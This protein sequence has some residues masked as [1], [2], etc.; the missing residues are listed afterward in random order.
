MTGKPVG[1]LLKGHVNTLPIDA[2]LSPEAETRPSVYGM[3][4]NV[5]PC[6][7]LSF[8]TQYI[9]T[10]LFGWTQMVGLE[11]QEMAFYIVCLQT[12]IYLLF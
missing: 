1:S 11:T 3:L 5:L 4:S 6:S 9:V 2:T 10:F 8:V 7:F 12:S